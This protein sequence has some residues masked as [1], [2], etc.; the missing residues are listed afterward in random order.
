MRFLFLFLVLSASAFGEELPVPSSAS[1]VAKATEGL[2][3]NKW[4]TENFVILSIDFDFGDGMRSSVE[5]ERSSVCAAWGV[6]D[7]HLPVKCKLVC[8]PDRKLLR[9]LF[10][11]DRPECEIRGEP[12]SPKE[13]AIWLDQGSVSSLRGLLL[14]VSLHGAPPC[15]QRGVDLLASSDAD[16]EIASLS[17]PSFAGV[18]SSTSESV[19]V[20]AP[21][22]KIIFDKESATLCLF[23]RRE[24]GSRAFSGLSKGASPER[25]C[26]FPDEKSFAETI[27]RY[28]VNLKEDLQSGRTPASYLEP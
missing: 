25:V 10:A 9:D 11:I 7:S 21:K 12:S 19:R 5:L 27:S 17:S 1:Q 22:D 26:G 14:S 18:F 28:F 24:F 13:M 3:W 23:V 4:E 20:M 16:K 15:V 2:V 8:V 6:A